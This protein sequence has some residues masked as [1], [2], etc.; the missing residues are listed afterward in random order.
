MV[1]RATTLQPIPLIPPNDA[2]LM[3][4]LYNEAASCVWQVRHAINI[5]QWPY[6]RISVLAVTHKIATRNEEE[7]VAIS[8][9]FTS[10]L[11]VHN[12]DEGV[13]EVLYN[14]ANT[15]LISQGSGREDQRGNFPPYFWC[16]IGCSDQS[17]RPSG[18]KSIERDYDFNVLCLWLV[19]TLRLLMYFRRYRNRFFLVIR[20]LGI[21]T[22]SECK[23]W[24]P[25]VATPNHSEW[26]HNGPS[27]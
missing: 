13:T 17:P 12:K 1:K 23:E 5:D 26:H 6:A 8:S 18:Q 2:C 25:E 16:W 14:L 19:D 21:F 9:K 10:S 3:S 24:A 11:R 27:R 20:R 4:D 7:V 22:E 15:F